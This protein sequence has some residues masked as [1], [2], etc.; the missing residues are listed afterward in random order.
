MQTLG[1]SAAAVEAV[2]EHSGEPSWMRERRREAW[3]LYEALPL[4]DP[5]SEAWRRTD[6][7]GL[8]LD[9]LRVPLDGVEPEQKEGLPSVLAPA[10]GGEEPAGLLVQRDG[11]TVQA[12]LQEAVARQGVLFLDLDRATAQVPELVRQHFLSLVSPHELKFRALHVAL[13]RGGTLLYVPPGVEV[14]RPLVSASWVDTPGA[15]LAPHTLLVAGE[16]SRV[17]L[18]DL[19]ASEEMEAQTVVSGA[20]ELVVG[21][22]AQVRYVAFQHWGVNVWEFGLIRAHLGR[23]ATLASLVAGFG[24]SLVK[25]DVESKL[26]G[27]GAQSEMLGLYFASDRQH[28]DYHTL[29]E[30]LAAHT[31]SDLLYKG[32]VKDRGRTVFAGLIRVHPGAQKTNAFQSNRNLLLNAGARSDSIPKLEI[33]ANDLRCTHGSATSRLNDEQLFYLMSRGLRRQQAV[34]M[35]VDGFFAEVLDRIP[36]ERLR[37]QVQE[38]IAGKIAESSQG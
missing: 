26:Q 22:G 25:T 2:G 36:L 3:R 20:V 7:S 38:E 5:T 24:G 10:L 19:F 16:G 34:Q 28:F 17:T 1:L 27:P 15:L 30:H 6:I 14:A 11:Q 29:Q 31:L 32:A 13:R 37:Q 18:V 8:R 33:M 23:D 12:A 4:P 21:D 35:V 9:G